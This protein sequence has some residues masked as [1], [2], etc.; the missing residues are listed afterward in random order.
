MSTA[1]QLDPPAPNIKFRRLE[2]QRE[3]QQ[4]AAAA[5][6]LLEEVRLLRVACPAGEVVRRASKRT[7]LPEHSYRVAL[8]ELAREGRIRLTGDLQLIP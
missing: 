2:E 5:K 8:W 1:E 6:A 3:R 7:R 4:E